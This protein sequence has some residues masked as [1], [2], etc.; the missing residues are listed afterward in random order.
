[1]YAK[2]SNYKS[3]RQ[4]SEEFAIQDKELSL[5]EFKSTEEKEAIIKENSN[6][7]VVVDIFAT[8][9]GPCKAIVPALTKII[10]KYPQVKFFKENI[11]ND[12]SPKNTVTAVPTFHFFYGGQFIPEVTLVGANMND[13]ESNINKVLGSIKN[14]MPTQEQGQGKNTQQKYS[15]PNNPGFEERQG[16]SG[17]DPRLQSMNVSSMGVDPRM[18][19]MGVDPRMGQSAPV[20]IVPDPRFNQQQQNTMGQHRGPN[21]QNYQPPS[22][23]YQSI[24]NI[25]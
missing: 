22:Q 14:Q 20:P 5:H 17:I 18:G 9:C 11:E 21:Q 3:Y 23:T 19:P 16:P 2:P 1:M 13:L 12:L 8:W 10:Q 6:S 15:H 25:H 4:Y 7:L 24:R